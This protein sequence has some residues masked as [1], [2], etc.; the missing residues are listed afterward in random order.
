MQLDTNFKVFVHAI[1]GGSY[2]AAVQF[3]FEYFFLLAKS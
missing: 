2:I 3:E 1:S